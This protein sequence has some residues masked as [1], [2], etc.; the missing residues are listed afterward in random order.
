MSHP[1]LTWNITSLTGEVRIICMQYKTLQKNGFAWWLGPLIVNHRFSILYFCQACIWWVLW[2]DYN[3]K[4]LLY[5]ERLLWFAEPISWNAMSCNFNAQNHVSTI[6]GI[7]YSSEIALCKPYY[8]RL[9]KVDGK[10]LYSFDN[11]H[12]YF[13]LQY[14]HIFR[15]KNRIKLWHQYK[16]TYI[17]YSNAK[18]IK[19]YVLLLAYLELE[20]FNYTWRVA[21]EIWEY[22]FCTLKYIRG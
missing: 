4:N 21:N 15:N 7:Y 12:A 13:I 16:V 6:I 5:S 9:N 14:I 11:W 18:I 8:T 10:L 17:L 20:I 3:Y 2:C 22:S 1:Y 19:T